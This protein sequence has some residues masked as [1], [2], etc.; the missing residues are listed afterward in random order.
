MTCW[1]TGG[2][3]SGPSYSEPAPESDTIFVQGLDT[4]A[5]KE[6]I[7]AFFGQ[8]GIIKVWWHY[9]FYI[10]YLLSNSCSMF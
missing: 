6:E 10:K 3:P 8:I 5:S 9:P 7:A 2:A 1:L 4:T